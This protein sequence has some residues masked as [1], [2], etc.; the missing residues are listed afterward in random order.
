[1]LALLLQGQGVC[2]QLLLRDALR[3][4]DIRHPGL[5]AGDGAG[6][7]QSH[8]LHPARFLQ[9]SGSLEQD[10]V[11]GAHAVAH[12]DGH[13]RGKAQGTGAADDQHR[14]APRQ[15][16]AD[17]PPQ[18]QPDKGGDHCNADDCRHEK[19]GYGICDL[20]NGSFCCS[21]ITDHADDL[22]Q[23]G[24]LAHAGSTAL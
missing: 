16:V 6:F 19:A 24:V 14:D 11:F 3:R 17:V 12:H 7:V 22:R 1:M 23:R 13:R 4:K 8:D 18:Q 15:R 2:Q 20:C 5:T 10:A 21:C 9:G